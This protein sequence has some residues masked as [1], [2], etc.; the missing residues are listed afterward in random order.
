M[1]KTFV[2]LLLLACLL[3]AACKTTPDVSDIVVQKESSWFSDFEVV[4][5]R[6]NFYC[7]LC[8]KNTGKADQTISIYGNFDDDV[9]GGLVTEGRLLARDTSNPRATA[10]YVPGGTEISVKV[11]FTGTFAGTAEKHDRL[12][13]TLEIVPS[14]GSAI[15]ADNW[16]CSDPTEDSAEESAPP[17]TSE[18]PTEETT[19][20]L[21]AEPATVYLIQNDE[22]CFVKA[23]YPQFPSPEYDAVNALIEDYLREQVQRI[24]RDASDPGTASFVTPSDIVWED[25]PQ[26]YL[27]L[28]YRLTLCTEDTVSV[29]FEGL[30]NFKTAAHPLHEFLSLNVDPQTGKEIALSDRFAVDDALYETFAAYAE[31]D[32]TQKLDGWP[33]NWKS[34]SEAICSKERFLNG[35]AQGN[36]FYVFF[37][38]EGV[39]VSYP[40]FHVMGDHMEIVLPYAELTETN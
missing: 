4:G 5:D 19:K 27:D 18:I 35:V 24:C 33:E 37:T 32:L 7:I 22:T 31:A 2:A 34:F 23:A 10:F 13:P 21:L 3:C 1:K 39:G 20:A 40:I 15:K 6:V 38:E 12:L 17:Q 28:D 16:V 11:V 25:L 29:V 36:E 9:R 8:L 26:Y 14:D 30:Y